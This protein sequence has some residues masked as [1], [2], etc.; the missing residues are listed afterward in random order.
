MSAPRTA[1][2]AAWGTAMDEEGGLGGW[3][4][5][6]GGPVVD[7]MSVEVGSTLTVG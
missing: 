2:K 3:P 1:Q 4:V 6:M 7:W 5:V